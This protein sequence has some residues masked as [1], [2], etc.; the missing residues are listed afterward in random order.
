MYGPRRQKYARRHGNLGG[1]KFVSLVIKF[2]DSKVGKPK[3][4]ELFFLSFFS[5]LDV[6]L[7]AQICEISNR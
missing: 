4:N 1:E 5:D 2:N 3:K 6:F 7:I